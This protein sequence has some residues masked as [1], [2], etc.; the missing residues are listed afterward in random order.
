[1]EY[2]PQV[3]PTIDPGILNYLR[4]F[5]TL[6][7]L[8]CIILLLSTFDV[9]NVCGCLS[10][11]PF[12]N[13]QNSHKATFSSC[14]SWPPFFGVPTNY[15]SLP[16]TRCPAPLAGFDDTLSHHFHGTPRSRHSVQPQSRVLSSHAN[17]DAL[18]KQT[19]EGR[20]GGEGERASTSKPPSKRL[21]SVWCQDIHCTNNCGEN[22]NLSL[23]LLSLG[24][25]V[26]GLLLP[27]EFAQQHLVDMERRE[28]LSRRLT[29]P[30]NS[31]RRS[32]LS[33]Q[34]HIPPSGLVAER[35]AE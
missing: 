6:C 34:T 10:C 14:A 20:G 9:P 19:T 7:A 22:I 29:V 30:S 15:P 17:G 35:E 31:P 28:T 27:D 11:L 2:D 16:P 12:L 5:P 33:G 18:H 13:D 8:T 25:E 24:V 1:M 21:S 32:A 4:P 26:V 3:L 23:V